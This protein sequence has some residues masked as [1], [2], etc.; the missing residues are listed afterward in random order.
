MLGVFYELGKKKTYA[1]LCS[2]L[3]QDNSDLCAEFEIFESNKDNNL[4]VP[5]DLARMI[6]NQYLFLR[7][8]YE[9]FH[10]INNYCKGK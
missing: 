1:A 7:N 3:V 10:I 2:L 6:E 8:C 4:D 9:D 5:R